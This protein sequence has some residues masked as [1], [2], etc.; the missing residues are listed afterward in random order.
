MTTI[1]VPRKLLMQ[2]HNELVF[3]VASYGATNDGHLLL[4]DVKSFLNAPKV[5]ERCGISSDSGLALCA[6]CNRD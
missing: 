1:Q 3:Y 5:C 2:L 6:Q 4:K